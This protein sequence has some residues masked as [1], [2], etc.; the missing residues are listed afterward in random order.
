MSNLEKNRAGHYVQQASNYRC[1]IPSPLPPDPPVRI[2]G[3]LL[4][5]LSEADRAIG[6]LDSIVELIP[7]PD[8]FIGLFSRKE[9]VH[10]SQI[11]GTQTTLSELLFFEVDQKQQSGRTDHREVLNYVEALDYGLKR[12]NELPISVRLIKELHKI[13][14]KDVRGSD[15]APGELRKTQVHIGAPGSSVSGATYVPP[16][17]NELPKTLGELE[18]FIHDDTVMPVLVKCGLIHA[19]FEMIHPF[20]DGNGRIGRLLITLILCWKKILKKPLLYISQ[21]FNVNRDEYI[22][23]LRSISEHGDWEGWIGYFL[24]AVKTV[25]IQSDETGHKILKLRD[26]HRELVVAEFPK[27]PYA[28]NVLEYMFR[29][30]VFNPNKMVEIMGHS[31]VT[32]YNMLKEFEKLGIITEISGQTRNRVFLYKQYVDL[33]D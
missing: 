26:Q 2:D 7:N 4:V 6:R 8:L 9:A 23:R 31:K 19:Q 33:F 14:L 15:R 24:T 13:L 5:L 1:F 10:S 16:P 30:P 17:A 18:K 3:E 21:F 12:L 25:A 20:F 11:E 29:F 28:L 32:I 27:S 22:R